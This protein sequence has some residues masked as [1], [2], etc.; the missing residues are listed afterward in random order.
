MEQPHESKTVAEKSAK[1]TVNKIGGKNMR[2]LSQVKNLVQILQER[3]EKVVLVVSAFEKVTNSLIAGMDELNGQDYTEEDIEK[4]FQQTQKL[5]FEIIE[6]YFHEKDKNHYAKAAQEAY[7]TAFNILKQ[8]L[9]THKKLSKILMPVEGSFQIR[10]QVIGFGENMAAKFLDIYLAQEKIKADVFEN[11]KCDP[12]IL[13]NSNTGTI[14]S[15]KIQ[16]GIQAGIKKALTEKETAKQTDEKT[17]RIFGGHIAGTP[18]GIAIDEGRGYSDITGVDMAVTLER[19]GEKVAATRF[20]KDVDGISTANPKELDS[21]KNKPF[22][23]G[24]ISLEEVLEISSAGSDLLNVRALSRALQAG[25]DLEVRNINK[26]EQRGTRIT[27][28]DVNTHHAFKTIVSNPHFDVITVKI[29]EMADQSGFGAAIMQVFSKY[30]I[31]IEG[32]FSEGTSLTF[33][34]SMPRDA[35]DR[36]EQRE[37]IRSILE[38]LKEID[39]Q[40]ERYAITQA[41][42]WQ[43]GSLACISVIGKELHGRI[44]ILSAISGSLS[45]FG[46]N[47]QGVSHGGSQTRISFLIDQQYREQAVQVLHSIF[48]DNDQEVIKKFH[49]AHVKQLE[50]LTGTYRAT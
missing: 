31:S 6:K 10:D 42:T 20:W 24:D 39:V 32:P 29:P 45:A 17:V 33:G 14:S 7:Q 26:P 48:V 46:I 36:E 15:R 30:D 37:K 8:A 47:I 35:S 1:T 40:G 12:Q 2:N 22:V 25:L 9:M 28:G 49:E 19:I 5:H 44:G 21:R 38:E 27:Q 13:Q 18:R 16:E 43:K 41:P 23:H 11:V 50:V 4:A 3:K 34:I